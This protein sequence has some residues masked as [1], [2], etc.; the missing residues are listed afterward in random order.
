MA[1]SYYKLYKTDVDNDYFWVR[2]ES[3]M[4][5]TVKLQ[6]NGSKSTFVNENVISYSKDKV[7]WNSTDWTLN[8][9]IYLEPYQKIYLRSL[10]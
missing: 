10:P 7:N 3:A 9:D 5:A 1:T 6:V 2:N 8:T 4:K